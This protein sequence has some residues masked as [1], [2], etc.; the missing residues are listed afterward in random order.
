MCLSSV[1]ACST[2]ARFYLRLARG[3]KRKT[4]RQQDSLVFQRM[5][6]A[7]KTVQI[8]INRNSCSHVLRS[9]AS[10]KAIN[11]RLN[12]RV[13]APRCMTTAT[14]TSVSSKNTYVSP[15]AP[16]FKN[17]ENKRTSLGTPND[18]DVRALLESSKKCLK[19]GIPEDVLIFKAVS[20]GRSELSPHV[21]PG[22]HQITLYVKQRDLPLNKEELKIFR[23]IVGKR[24]FLEDRQQFRLISGY[25][26]SRIE[27][28]RHVVSMLD[29]LVLASQ[30]LAKG[31]DGDEVVHEL[32]SLLSENEE[33]VIT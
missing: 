2:V 22:E 19:C 21:F 6:T 32:R 20:Y 10:S 9:H 13:K 5:A 24:R 12:I 15:L 27:N 28:K 4:K 3:A 33:K 7:S 17:I 18:A 29:R 26:A 8:L 31:K 16:F 1:Q 30:L 11:V 14:T 23:R 25:F